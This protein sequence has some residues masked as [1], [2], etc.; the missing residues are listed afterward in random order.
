MGYILLEVFLF[1]SMIHILHSVSYAWLSV[2]VTNVLVLAVVV[3]AV[4]TVRVEV[5]ARRGG[6]QLR[7][8]RMR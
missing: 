6:G 4:R 1:N 2:I 5:R 8:L 3:G 7:A